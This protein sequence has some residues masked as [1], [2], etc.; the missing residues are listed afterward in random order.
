MN[1]IADRV[2]IFL[3]GYVSPN[4]AT[5][6]WNFKFGYNDMLVIVVFSKNNQSIL[7]NATSIMENGPVLFLP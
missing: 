7:Q 6:P 2:L 3:V 4:N 1:V 5:Q